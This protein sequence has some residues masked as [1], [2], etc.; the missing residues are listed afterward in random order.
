MLHNPHPG[1]RIVGRLIVFSAIAVALPLTA[2]HAIDYVD[3][4][5]PVAAPTP[6]TATVPA[7]AAVPVTAT[8]AVA[9]V[10]PVHRAVLP[11][12][13]V[14]VQAP[15]QA[16]GAPR[17]VVY[18]GMQID[19]DHVI[20]D[21]KSKRWEDLTP[22][23]R[24]RVRRA[25]AEA[26]ASLANV[27][28]N[29]DQIARQVSQAMSHVRIGDIQRDVAQAQANAA[30]AMRGID[31]ND[32]YIR[33]VGRDPKQ[34]EIDVGRSL[35]SVQA[36]DVEAIRRQLAAI[37]PAKLAKTMS[38]SQEALRAASAQLD[39]IQVRIDSDQHH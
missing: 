30:A 35:R 13:A 21:G 14:A 19:E 4:P 17:H 15:V 8:A 3:T 7:T 25:V 27:H 26:R 1:R 31:P 37:D 39:R 34:I 38:D 22:A 11:A 18:D 32:T 2:S 29:S 9:V 24:D 10:P 33:A 28:I 5:V 23:E 6:A 36:I 16:A 20:I 12:A